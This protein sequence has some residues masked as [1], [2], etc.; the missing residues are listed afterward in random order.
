[1]KYSRDR[2]DLPLL[3][4]TT[5]LVPGYVDTLEVEGIA[6]FLK[7]LDKTI[8]Y[9]L[10]VFHPDFAMSDLPVTPRRQVEDCLAAAKKHL[11]NVNVGNIQNLEVGAQIT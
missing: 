8:P 10:L 1:M 11:T 7:N 5:L 9:S 2:L 4:A 6:V 3:A